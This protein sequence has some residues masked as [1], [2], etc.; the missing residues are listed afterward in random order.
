MP[1]RYELQLERAAERSLSRISVADY[2]RLEAAIDRLAEEPRPRGSLKLQSSAPLFRIRVGGYRVIY[3]V[4]D[5]ERLVKILQV[6]KRDDQT[7]RN[8]ER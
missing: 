4:F 7:Y 2:I 8:L 3:A 1:D 5:D 6:S